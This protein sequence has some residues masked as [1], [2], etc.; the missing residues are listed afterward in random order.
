[1]VVNYN[2][3]IVIGN[4]L[5]CGIYVLLITVLSDLDLAF[6]RFK[7]GKVIYLPRS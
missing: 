7:K 1:M 4:D 3:I 5:P 6:G 2:N